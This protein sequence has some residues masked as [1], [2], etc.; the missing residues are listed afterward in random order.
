MRSNT[1]IHF[2][3]FMFLLIFKKPLNFAVFD[4]DNLLRLFNDLA[5]HSNKRT[6]FHLFI[7]LT[8]KHIFKTDKT[9]M[10]IYIRCVKKN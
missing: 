6:Y 1:F 7:Y 3:N 4:I 5:L 9:L 2:T 8:I 10:H